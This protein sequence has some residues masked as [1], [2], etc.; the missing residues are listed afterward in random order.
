V[1][2]KQFTN[3]SYIRKKITM[4]KYLA[5][6]M[7]LTSSIASKPAN[8]QPPFSFFVG[9]YTANKSEGIYSYRL[10][11]DGSLDS[12]GLAATMKNPSFLAKSS[13]NNFLL[14]VSEVSGADK[15]GKVNAYRINGNDLVLTGSATSGGGHPCF[16]TANPRGVVLVANYTGGN[17]GVL[18]MDTN[19]KLSGLLDLHQHE[20]SGTTDRQRGPHAHSAWFVPGTR[21][22]IEVDLGTNELWLSEIGEKNNKLV[23]L[24]QGNLEMNPGAGPRHLD[25]HP[26]GRWIY[27]VN[28]LDCTIS[29]V[30]RS[31]KGVYT[32]QN[33]FS[34]LPDEY[35]GKKSSADIH[36]SADGRFVYASN[37]GNNSIAIFSVDMQ[38]GNLEIAGFREVMGKTP[39][40]F[41]LSPDGKYLVVANQDSDNIVSFKRDPQT[42]L[43]EFVAQ[44][45][46]P[47]PVCI[48]F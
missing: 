10:N 45:P 3:S 33:T 27:V 18:K 25:F 39:R 15:T 5:T 38:T 24:E 12:I 22:V 1:Q 16:V 13:D 41:A 37:R 36:V 14:A 46:A 28:E 20:G 48:R 23:P 7:L 19:G 47:S 9:T 21:E 35:T 29:L 42:G 30:E 40:N 11:S 34:T 17:T 8:A 4:L 6:M 44:I 2:I 32:L 31:E 26:N 43:L